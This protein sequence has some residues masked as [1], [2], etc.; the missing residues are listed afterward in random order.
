M[1]KSLKNYISLFGG[2]PARGLPTPPPTPPRREIAHFTR[3]EHAS[4]IRGRDFYSRNLLG[5]GGGVG[6]AKQC[7]SLTDHRI[8]CKLKTKI[9]NIILLL[10]Y[11][12]KMCLS[13][14]GGLW[15]ASA[16][17]YCERIY[18]REPEPAASPQSTTLRSTVNTSVIEESR[19]QQH[20][21]ISKPLF[22]SR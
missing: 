20:T 11:L 14:S 13:P 22:F 4:A 12:D 1:E 19:P 6:N 15:Q 16:L 9:A 21:G 2:K 8:N 5:E 18:K 17:L 3:G 10:C 7:H